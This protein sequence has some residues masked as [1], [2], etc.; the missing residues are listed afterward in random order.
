MSRFLSAD[1]VMRDYLIGSSAGAPGF[2]PVAIRGKLYLLRCSKCG[3]AKW[4]KDKDGIERCQVLRTVPNKRRR[5]RKSGLHTKVCGTPR[6]W[7]SAAVLKRHVRES[8]RSDSG[9]AH[10]ER[11]AQLGLV[12]RRVL[13]EQQFRALSIYVQSGTYDAA[14]E[15]C[16]G[17][18]PWTGWTAS[19]LHRS[20]K[21]ARQLVEA[22]LERRAV[23]DLP[24]R[25]A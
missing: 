11:V 5:K 24:E 7:Q 12:L 2:D 13:S 23:F 19:L 1:D 18:W 9:S 8:R 21:E 6:P 16:R 10:A 15:Q 20:V 17:Q 22:R 25:A 14:L 4:R 3:G